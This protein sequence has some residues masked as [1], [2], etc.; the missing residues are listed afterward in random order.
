MMMDANSVFDEKKRLRSIAK[1]R[2][3]AINSEEKKA[4][5]L[6]L[7]CDVGKL[8]S[9]ETAELL[10]A[11]LSMPDEIDT[12]CIIE[13]AMADGKRVAVPRIEGE[14]IVFIELNPD[15][16]FWPLDRWNIPAPPAE[17]RALSLPE[18]LAQPC[19]ALIPGLAFDGKYMRL[20]RG[21]GFYDRFLAKLE[22]E[23]LKQWGQGSNLQDTSIDGFSTCGIGYACQFFD[24]VPADI[25]DR[26]L[27][28]LILA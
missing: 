13:K 9:Y 20:G 21:K 14:D 10:L 8:R 5:A 11:F 6:R 19:L 25:H 28:A 22:A 24:L 2:L 1:A 4:A 12:G 15:W 3:K 18:I 17:I 7:A 26:R 23:N 27:Y 16:K